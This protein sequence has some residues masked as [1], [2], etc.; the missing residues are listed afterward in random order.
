[1]KL[2]IIG[3]AHGKFKGLNSL[4]KDRTNPTIQ[5]GDMGLG[6][7]KNDPKEFA[8]HLYFIRGNHDDPEVCCQFPNYLGD[9]G[10]NKFLNI[11][12]VSGAW[13]IDQSFR[14]PFV[15]WWPDEELS[16]P[17]CS[18]VLALWDKVKPD[19]VITHDGP[20]VAT[21]RIL[22]KLGGVPIPTRM[23]QLFDQMWS[24]HKPKMWIFGHYHYRFQEKINGTDFYCVPELGVLNI[25]T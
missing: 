12:F 20:G 18:D 22:H 7:D 6:F 1:M 3:D 19:Y 21:Q 10:Y 9:F 25:E 14:I 4:L 11:F 17:Q 5:I 13:S 2:T 8:S 23:G 24:Y 15:S 16:L